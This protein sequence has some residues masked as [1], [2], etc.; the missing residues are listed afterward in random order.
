MVKV[1]PGDLLREILN[2]SEDLK[3]GYTLKEE[4]LDIVNHAT[5]E[6]VDNQLIHW[7]SKCIKEDV[8]E[9]IDKDVLKYIKENNLY[10]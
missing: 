3:K 4:F 2:I 9:F 6:D 10:E 7:I 1:L 5:L 8:E